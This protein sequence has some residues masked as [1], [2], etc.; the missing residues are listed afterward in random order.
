MSYKQERVQQDIAMDTLGAAEIAVVLEEMS[1]ER[2]SDLGMTSIMVGT[3]PKRG[4]IAV[5]NTAGQ[6]HAVMSIPE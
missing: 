6:Q 5:V 4:R 1:V 2:T 3:H